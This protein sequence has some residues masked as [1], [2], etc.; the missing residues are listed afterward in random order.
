MSPPGSI[1]PFWCKHRYTHGCLCRYICVCS[2]HNKHRPPGWL[3]I[4]KHMYNSESVYSSL[5]IV[6]NAFILIEIWV[7]IIVI[8]DT[9]HRIIYI[10]LGL[11]A[12][13][14]FPQPAPDA[15]PREWTDL[16]IHSRSAS[17]STVHPPPWKLKG[18]HRM[19]NERFL[20]FAAPLP[21]WLSWRVMTLFELINTW[22]AKELPGLW[23][24]W[25]S[26][27]EN[28]YHLTSSSL[29]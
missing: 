5:W 28:H 27:N 11:S 26:Q 24:K 22:R 16:F 10:P 17:P 7:L 15:E 2:T 9:G 20:H 3:Q 14:G 4:N 23:G 21:L 19:G 1:Q 18:S 13:S 6:D 25:Q 8:S 12:F 29:R